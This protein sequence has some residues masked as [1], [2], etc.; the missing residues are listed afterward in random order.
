MARLRSADQSNH[1]RLRLLVVVLFMVGVL[2]QSGCGSNPSS[3]GTPGR[4]V[5]LTFWNTM[6]DEEFA[7][8]K[9]LWPDLVTAFPNIEVKMEQVPF[10]KARSKFEQAVK[11]GV[12]PDLFRADRMWLRSF[13]AEGLIEGF[14][15]DEVREEYDDLLSI[16]R[17]GVRFDDR[18]WALPQSVDCLGL[19]Y[20][21]R[22][23]Q[24]AGVEPPRDF[25]EFRAAAKRLTD[26]RQG[27]YG[28]FMNPEGWWFSTFLHAFGGRFFEA[29]GTLAIRSDQTR[30]A[31]QFLIDL[32]ETDR[33]MPPVNVRSHSYSVMMQS[34]KSGQ[35][36]MIINGPWA[37]RDT[38]SGPSFK[39]RTDNLGIAPLPQGPLGRYT[40]IGCHTYVVSKKTR[41]RAEAL[42]VI[43]HLVGPSVMATISKRSFGLPA[44]KSLY[45][46][47]E[48]KND[49]YL[50]PFILQ[51][52]TALPDV[53]TH[54]QARIFGIVSDH[55]QRV[56][57]GDLTPNDALKDI[58]SAWHAKP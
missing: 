49:P 58:E 38:L 50:A 28:F 21:K 46:D 31:M 54:E 30:K 22:H 5:T 10:D 19:F 32:K 8:L 15:D 1:L 23:F 13:A 34:F 14:K 45:S 18:V 26:P 48:L 12:A 27:R 53:L 11:A 24:D 2:F 4:K 7:A 35:V 43:K 57:N 41:H 29:D 20:N 36:S 16:A 39:D 47:P 9:D 25:D 17:E 40:P 52:Q 33:I 51:L 56:L 44:R 3:Q 6:N 55:L 37:I 42:Q